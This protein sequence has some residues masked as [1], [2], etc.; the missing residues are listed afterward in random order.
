MPPLLK[1]IQTQ[2]SKSTSE[3]VR[4]SSMKFVP[5]AQKVY[6]VKMP[7]LNELAKKF[8]AGGFPLV[9]E[10]WKSGA[11]EERV[12]AAKILGRIAKQD[13]EKT[14][15]LIAAFSKDISDWAVCDTLGMQSPKK[16]NKSHSEEIFTL[17]EKL[18]YSKNLWQ[19]RLALVLAEW[20]TRDAAFHPRIKKLLQAVKNDKEYYV[21]K[22]VQWIG[23]NLAAR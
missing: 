17:S 22:A 19:R 2:L 23:R 3:A 1:T 12:L 15:K 8:D 4:A 6:G 9:E 16:I 5:G 18:I 21:K 7:V 10:L 14:L 20:Y 11:Y 13:A